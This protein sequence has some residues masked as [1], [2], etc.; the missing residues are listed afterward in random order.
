MPPSVVQDDVPDFVRTGRVINLPD[1]VTIT[2]VSPTGLY[3]FSGTPHIPGWYFNRPKIKKSQVTV[4][5]L[6]YIQNQLCALDPGGKHYKLVQT[7]PDEWAG[8]IPEPES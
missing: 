8:P 7:M 4:L 1:H 3:W 6:L 2:P 5:L